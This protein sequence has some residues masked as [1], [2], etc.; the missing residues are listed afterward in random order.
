MIN[1]FL[2][3]LC[4]VFVSEMSVFHLFSLYGGKK[5]YGHIAEQVVI[6]EE[7]TER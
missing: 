2:A 7:A 6:S 4:M 5:A 1:A 3:T